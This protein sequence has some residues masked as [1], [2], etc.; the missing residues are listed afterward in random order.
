M[1][2]PV[3]QSDISNFTYK[4]ERKGRGL[5]FL[6]N[7]YMLFAGREAGIGKNCARGLE[8][9]PRAQFFPI[10]TSRPANNVFIFS[11]RNYF[12]RNICVDFSLKLS[13]TVRVRLT[14]WTSN[15]R[16]IAEIMENISL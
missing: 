7:I 12:I 8:H 15:V 14:F 13:H 3:F 6:Y 11:M 2:F 5:F 16:Y 10:R 1:Y 4:L 9:G